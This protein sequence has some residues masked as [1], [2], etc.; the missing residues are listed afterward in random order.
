[1]NCLAQTDPFYLEHFKEEKKTLQTIRQSNSLSVTGHM[2]SAEEHMRSH[3]PFT[4]HPLGRA[5]HSARSTPTPACSQAAWPQEMSSQHSGHLP[6]L[7]G[8][9]KRKRA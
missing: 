4:G 8:L 6:V 7:L 5:G 1:M 9:I 2:V 3:R